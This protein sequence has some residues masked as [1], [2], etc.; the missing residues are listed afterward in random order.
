MRKR[1]ILIIAAVIV[2]LLAAYVFAVN[3]TPAEDTTPSPTPAAENIVVFETDSAQITKIAF[4][5]PTP[6]ALVKN[7]D[8]WYIEGNSAEIVQSSAFSILYNA[9]YI[10]ATTEI[11]KA[12]NLAD[13]GLDKPSASVT[14]YHGDS[15]TKLLLG[16][17]TPT[18][19]YYYFKLD[20]DSKVYTISAYTADLFFKTPSSVRDLN[21][22]SLS[23]DEIAGIEISSPSNTLK[24]VK[25][26]DAAK[27]DEKSYSSLAKW[28]V[29]SP[30]SQIAAE[31]RVN[32]KLLTP[33]SS[34]NAESVAA[35][36]AASLAKYNLNTTVKIQAADK[37]YSL[38]IGQADGVNYVYSP[39]KNI[40]YVVLKTNLS[41]LDVKAFDV[42]QRLI[43]FPNI[44]DLKSVEV[45]INS[46][47]A[48]LEREEKSENNIVYSINGENSSEEL[49]KSTYQS[50]M[51]LS[52]DGVLSGSFNKSKPFATILYTMENGSTE[53]IE[54]CDYDQFSAAVILNGKAQFYIKKTK[55]TE[56]EYVLE[57]L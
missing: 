50:I 16:S 14:V 43:T 1:N 29:T 22:I 49:F 21:I 11:K 52:V 40:V 51:G 45:K 13:F 42:I 24:V 53:K 17:K 18:D 15:I 2:L 23:T 35:D 32:E 20:S 9:A 37:T 27:A 4:D 39:E 28:M 10:S 19:N 25:N 5:S 47:S 7:G 12:E 46:F 44:S 34:I 41:F 31:E 33:L 54:L 48:L 26:T 30:V 55:I 8:T 57:T 36:G 38:K 6:F 3:Y 56:L